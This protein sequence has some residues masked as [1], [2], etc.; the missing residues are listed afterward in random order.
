MTVCT[1][2]DKP[3]AQFQSFGSALPKCRRPF[4]LMCRRRIFWGPIAVRIA[5]LHFQMRPTSPCTA[6]QSRRLRCGSTSLLHQRANFAAQLLEGETIGRRLR[7]PMPLPSRRDVRG[8]WSPA[9]TAATVE[10]DAPCIANRC[11]R[12]AVAERLGSLKTMRAVH[13]SHATRW[14]AGRSV[15][16]RRFDDDSVNEF[17]LADLQVGGQII[18]FGVSGTIITSRSAA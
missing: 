8:P 15:R 14:S 1:A 11:A 13:E 3:P 6:C 12:L 10:F 2:D 4:D 18:G 16:R 5:D 17:I 7:K 9:T